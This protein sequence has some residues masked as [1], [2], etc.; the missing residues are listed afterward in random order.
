M[1]GEITGWTR[2]MAWLLLIVNIGIVGT[3]GLVRLTG[4]GM[5]CETWP[6]C[7]SESL[8][9]T[10][11][12]GIHGLIEFGN[13]TLTGVLVIVALLAFLSVVRLRRERP[14]LMWLTFA[15]GIGIIVQAVVGGITVW[16]H[17]HPSVVGVHYLISAALVA[18]ATV[19]LVRVY[20]VP[21]PRERLVD[22]GYAI[23]THV[24]SLAVLVTVIVGILLT[25]SG[26]HAG[27][28]A[29]ARNGLDPIFWQHVHSWPAYATLALTI[30]IFAWSFRQPRQLHLTRWTG[31][32]L[33]V[34][35]VQIGVGLWQ[36]RTGLPIALVNIHM[37]LAVCLVAA[38]TV[39]VMHLKA[40]IARS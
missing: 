24:A 23:L 14:E 2:A 29:A 3:G 34:E 35:F 25:G 12:L 33:G 39:V 5:G 1:P 20:A 4:S 38:M 16:M 26:P 40:P 31:M 9:P 6:Y 7:T 32:L 15:V 18:I 19:H 17:L 11:E 13:R 30:A 36:A 22:R 8:V 37:V 21:G 10:P 28:D 27:D